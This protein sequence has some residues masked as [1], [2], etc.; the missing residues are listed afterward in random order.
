MSQPTK[1]ALVVLASIAATAALLAP[2]VAR[3]GYVNQTVT[4][5]RNVVEGGGWDL[6]FDSPEAAVGA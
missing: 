4:G 2:Q 6:V 3:A 1:K 5:C